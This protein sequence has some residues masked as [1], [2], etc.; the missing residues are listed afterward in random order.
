MAVNLSELLALPPEERM[1]LAEALLDSVARS[2]LEPLARA[3]RESME[4]TNHTLDATL[5]RLEQLKE[6]I[7]RDRIEVREAVRRSGE[8]WPFPLPWS[9]R[10][11]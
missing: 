9:R 7:E 5:V 3:F 2:E 10:A 4:R 8:E 1:R 11:P 6:T